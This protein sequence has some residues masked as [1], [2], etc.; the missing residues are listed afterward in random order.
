MKD[1]PFHIHGTSR[2]RL[3]Q[4]A[5]FAGFRTRIVKREVKRLF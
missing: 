2:A 3:L 5:V 4:F 1:A